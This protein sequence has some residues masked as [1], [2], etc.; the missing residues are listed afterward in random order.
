MVRSGAFALLFLGAAAGG[1]ACDCP[2]KP[3]VCAEFWNPVVVFVGRVESRRF[4]T[5]RDLDG[6]ERRFWT[7]RFRVLEELKGLPGAAATVRTPGP[8]AACPLEF[9]SGATYIVYGTRAGQDFVTGPCSRTHKIDGDPSGDADVAWI[10]ALPDAPRG[11]TIFGVVSAGDRGPMAG[12][13]VR[14]DGPGRL[15]ATTGVDGRYRIERLDPGDYRVTADVAGAAA[16][17]A[18]VADRACAE[19][20][21]TATR[22]G[23]IRGRVRDAAGRPAAGVVVELTRAG[24]ES[25]AMSAAT[26]REGLFEFTGAAPH[27]KYVLSVAEGGRRVY[28]PGVRNLL[29][30]AAVT[31][32]DSVE[33]QLPE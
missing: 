31:A 22:G 19:V 12:V 24:A 20:D 8:D 13:R 21:F 33:F 32:G 23:S 5:A 3:P 16:R 25:P 30:A 28:Y 29:A 14:A 7:T 17:D 27:E 6:S 11:G 26:N 1:L 2:P 10:R 9:A 15:E 4:E 18:S